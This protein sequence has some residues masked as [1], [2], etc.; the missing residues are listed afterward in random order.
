MTLKVKVVFCS[1]LFV[2]CVTCEHVWRGSGVEGV[3]YG[4]EGA[5]HGVHMEV[6]EKL[7]ALSYFLPL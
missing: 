3:M 6:R 7:A 2:V 5:Y 4:G 1:V